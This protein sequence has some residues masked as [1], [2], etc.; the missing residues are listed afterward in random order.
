M[1][2][3]TGLVQGSELNSIGPS[4]TPGRA[5]RKSV[6]SFE[7]VNFLLNQVQI[8]QVPKEQRAASNLV[9]VGSLSERRKHGFSLRF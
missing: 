8:N 2:L 3:V 9:I 7:T 4:S 5:E 6:S 1:C